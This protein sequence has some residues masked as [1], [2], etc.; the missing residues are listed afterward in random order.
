MIEKL[1]L[2]SKEFLANEEEMK[3]NRAAIL[4]SFGMHLA[5]AYINDCK[6]RILE[7]LTDHVEPKQ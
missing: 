1:S 2:N 6:P 4:V 3:V 7:S 5:C